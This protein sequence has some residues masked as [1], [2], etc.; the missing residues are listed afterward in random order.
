[1]LNFNTLVNLVEESDYFRLHELLEDYWNELLE[2]DPTKIKV[3]GLIQVTVAL[4]HLKNANQKGFEILKEKGLKKLK[5][6]D[7]N[8]ELN[9]DFLKRQLALILF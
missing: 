6:N 4:H 3:Q 1:M 2:N 9:D 8:T 5:L 7:L